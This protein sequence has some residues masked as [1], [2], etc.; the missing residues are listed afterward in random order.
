MIPISWD[1]VGQLPN[2]SGWSGTHDVKPLP[3]EIDACVSTL[4]PGLAVYCLSEVCGMVL[5]ATLD[6]M[7]S[8]ISSVILSK[9]STDS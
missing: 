6:S 2:A 7:M 4:C 3:S 1:R 5:K 8:S 9:E